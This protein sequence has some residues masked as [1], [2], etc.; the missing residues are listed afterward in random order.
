VEELPA[1]WASAFAPHRAL[2]LGVSGD[3]TENLLW[4]LANGETAG[5]APKLTVLE[6]GTN[7]LGFGH[8]AEATAYG[9]QAVV[10]AF[11]TLGRLRSLSLSCQACCRVRCALAPPLRL[12]HARAAARAATPGRCA[13]CGRCCRRLASP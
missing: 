8:S 10:R 13:R 5:L 2:A 4:R 3:R 11:A 1:V 6:I 12:T 9:V 7:N